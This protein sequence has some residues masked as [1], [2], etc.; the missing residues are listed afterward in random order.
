ML[1]LIRT[2][3][4]AFRGLRRQ[5]SFSF[6]VVAMLSLGIA[7]TSAIFSLVHSLV[8][9]PLSF[10]DPERLVYLDETAPK[11]NL[12]LVSIC[13][14]DFRAWREAN[15]SFDSMAL[16]RDRAFNLV[17][18]GKA[19][20]IQGASV[21]H[22]LLSVL[23]L[24]PMFGRG[25]RAEEELAGAPKV[26][27]LSH[28]LWRERFGGDTAVL[29][30][31][32]RLDGEPFEIVGVLPPAVRYPA[33]ARLWVPN[34]EDP[35]GDLGNYSFQGIGRLLAGL[36]PTQAKADLDRAL[37]PLIETYP[38]KQPVSSVVK[39]LRDHYV[40]DSRTVAWVL[41]VAVALVL[42]IACANVASLMLA[43]GAARSREIS[44]HLAI[45]ATRGRV[46]G[47]LLSESLAL[48]LVGGV[49]GVVL[50]H[51]GLRALGSMV[52]GEMPF[53]V[54]FEPNVKALSISF[55]AC[56]LTALVFGLLPAWQT[57]RVDLRQALGAHNSRAGSG[58]GKNRTL[59]GLVIAEMAV[60]QMLLIGA[61]LVAMSQ[62]RVFRVDPG[63]RI[64][65][66]LTFKIQL[67]EPIYVGVAARYRFF[68]EAVSR[69]EAL[70]GVI[71][72]AVINKAP[73]QGHTGMFFEAEGQ[74]RD[75]DEQNPVILTRLAT[76]RY[77]E[78]LGVPLLRG[79]NLRIAGVGE[80]CPP[81]VVVNESFA[82]H[83]WG[84]E[85]PIGRR[86]RNDD[87]SPWLTVIGLARDVHQYGLDRDPR[88]GIYLPMGYLVRSQMTLAVHTAVDPTTIVGPVRELVRSMDPELP[89]FGVITM[90]QQLHRSLTLRRLTAWLFGLFAAI[91]LILAAGGA[92]GVISY[93]V[94]QRRREI[95]IRKALGARR[96]QLVRDVLGRGL[97]LAGI[98]TVLGVTLA[99]ALSHLLATL[100]FGVDTGDL[101]IFAAASTTLLAVAL[102]ANL[103]PA[104]R[105][106]RLDAMRVLREE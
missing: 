76:D 31:E 28:G 83:F 6:L 78:T 55:A 87:E 27:I 34:T 95:G 84:D 79:R 99:A 20:R 47:Q 45:G 57:T 64:D 54:S 96:A 101:R 56:V 2:L 50:G 8:L 72:A 51:F 1:S 4:L 21:T 93:G 97:T 59:S 26:V 62:F 60:A 3:R 23:R 75:P 12:E 25:F 100:L 86:I 82:H 73:L 66:V 69:L 67:P 49:A 36:T 63:F 16:V 38:W 48:A 74:V 58:P 104:F 43:R 15:S 106:A 81:E 7:G 52:A 68:T 65:N 91:A 18:D 9:E 61:S 53:W 88:P 92:Y 39:P 77:L 17:A 11:W 105:A 29:G 10:E 5:P 22:E 103:V 40:E 37:L 85:D 41:M 80:D 30:R 24:R 42:L 32:L 33:E 71:S 89:L 98:G 14:A 35:E 90:E 46:A 70:P 102:L 13:V 94:S 44:I 19:E